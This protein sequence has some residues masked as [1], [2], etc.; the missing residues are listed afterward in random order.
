M[1]RDAVVVPVGNRRSRH[2]SGYRPEPLL[3]LA[4]PFR[5]RY[6]DYRQTWAIRG[7]RLQP[8]AAEEATGRSG[9]P[10]MARLVLTAI[11]VHCRKSR[12]QCLRAIRDSV[13]ISGKHCA[14]DIDGVRIAYSCCN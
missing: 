5:L 12:H 6:S 4:V 8:F 9:Y 1:E 11:G 3:L 13:L 14:M 10:F 2:Y 7:D